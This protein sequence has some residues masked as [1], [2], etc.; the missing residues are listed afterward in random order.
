MSMIVLCLLVLLR[1]P[2]ALQSITG[3]EGFKYQAG[4]G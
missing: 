3:N 4:D 2:T 1:I